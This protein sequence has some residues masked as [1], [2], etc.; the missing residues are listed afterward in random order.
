M[1]FY[2]SRAVVCST[3]GV[4]PVTR[5]KSACRPYENQEFCQIEIERG[6]V[7]AFRK[8]AIKRETNAP[9]LIRQLLDTIVDD[10]LV[11]AILDDRAS[12]PPDRGRGRP[13]ATKNSR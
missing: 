3:L 4:A 11:D 8:D 2:G 1:T 5:P 6:T 9:T 13:F 10:Q 12:P 7:T